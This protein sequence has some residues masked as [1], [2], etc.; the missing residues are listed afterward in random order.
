MLAIL[1]LLLPA[2]VTAQRLP[3]TVIPV[4][5]D[6]TFAPDFSRDQFGGEARVMVSVQER[7]TEI[8]MHAVEIEIHEVTVDSGGETQTAT[9]QAEPQNE[10][11][12]L[13]VGKPLEQG[14]ATIHIRYTGILN[15]QLAGLYLGRANGRKYATT[16]MEATDARRAFPS[17]DEPA[18]KAT[19]S[20]TAIVAEGDTALSN[21]SVLSDT[22][23]PAGS[24]TIRFSTTPR[25]S[26]YLVALTVGDFDCLEDEAEG[27][28]LGICGTPDKLRLGEFSM[29]ASKFILR[30]LNDYY[31]IPYP[32]HKLDQVGVADFRAGAMENFGSII[33]RDSR[34]FIDPQEA[35][36]AEKRSIAGIIGHEIAHM[37][38]GDLVTMQWWDDIWLNEGFARWMQTKP[39]A[40]WKPEWN[41]GLREV[42]STG[43]VVALD[44][45]RS[46]RPI[47]QQATTPDEIDALFDGIAYG[48]TA[49]VLR[50]VES[51]VGEDVMKKGISNY[52]RKHSWGN[53]T[54]F[55]FADAIEGASGKPVRAMLHSYIEQAGIPVVS[56]ATSCE[57]GRTIARLSQE[58]FL[59]D[60]SGASESSAGQVWS[61]PVCFSRQDGAVSCH[62]LSSAEE[63]VQLEGCRGMFPNADGHG[64][65]VTNP[66]PADLDRLRKD[67]GGFD[68]RERLVLLRDQWNLVR[69][70]E[71]P[72]SDY[73]A[74]VD[75][76]SDER[77]L[78]IL[79]MILEDLT[80]LSAQMVGESDR[81]AFQK[82]TSSLL[83]PI[84]SRLGWNR[85]NG[86]TEEESALRAEIL[87]TLGY[88]GGDG[89]VL[90]KARNLVDRHL[91]GKEKLDPAL[92]DSMVALAATRGDRRLYDRYLKAFRD[93]GTPDERNLFMLSL[94]KFEDPSLLR[95]TL[96]LAL[97]DEIK[98]QDAGR[99]IAAVIVNPKGR[100]EGWSFVEKQWDRI[101]N[102]LPVRMLGSVLGA[103]EHF[104]GTADLERVRKFWEGHRLASAE[105]RMSQAIERVGL[106]SEMKRE[107]GPQITQW[108]AGRSS[109]DRVS[110][111]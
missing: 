81:E 65:Y 26:S 89:K 55:D 78:P 82:W 38:F 99:V 74:L 11:V 85:V 88:V 59:L 32:Y 62:M 22:P 9:V 104:C 49:A 75:A 105:R 70:G 46:S 36:A 1:L 28:S 53:A 31:G 79:K 37:W 61:V 27:V 72:V 50:M 98:S 17:F 97:T 19:F 80:F 18:M 86:E 8:V 47:R 43:S 67:L 7:V 21:G 71:R 52:L 100:A 87:Y 13:R 33:Y 5:Y 24:R 73:L 83:V 63:T 20:I 66:A 93:A 91:D 95:R 77:E 34:L 2:A 92:R 41:V 101:S 84:A 108:L 23:G 4:H 39:L 14:L 109:E 42:E 51:Y 29:E 58:R 57:N 6:L 107:V 25:M 3:K 76:L 12:R 110:A 90:Q 48:K 96:D 69:A 111:P 103:S 94:A 16:Q 54:Y 106:C 40:E 15:D 60:R 56:V 35:T 45:L 68:P 30:Y 10:W 102:K 44:A 64:Y